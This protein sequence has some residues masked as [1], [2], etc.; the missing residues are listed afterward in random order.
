MKLK[1]TSGLFLQTMMKQAGLFQRAYARNLFLQ[2]VN[3]VAEFD[4]AHEPL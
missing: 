1:G 3:D 4:Q 2:E